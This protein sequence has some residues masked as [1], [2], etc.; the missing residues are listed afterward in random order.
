[1]TEARWTTS[2][3]GSWRSSPSS[4]RHPLYCCCSKRRHRPTIGRTTP[5]ARLIR[6]SPIAT[7]RATRM[8]GPLA[9]KALPATRAPL[10]T[11]PRA[12]NRAARPATGPSKKR[13]LKTTAIARR[14]RIRRNRGRRFGRLRVR[15]WVSSRHLVAVRGV[16]AHTGRTQGTVRT[17]MAPTTRTT[18]PVMD[19]HRRTATVAGWGLRARDVSVMLTTSSRRGKLRTPPI[20]TTAT[21][22]TGTA[23]SAR[24]IRLTP[25]ASRRHHP[26]HVARCHRVVKNHRSHRGPHVRCR[27]TRCF[28]S[29]RSTG[30]RHVS[31]SRSFALVPTPQ[32][33]LEP[34][35]A[36]LALGLWVSV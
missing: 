7:L 28:P 15:R 5:A 8:R 9:K 36:H 32:C 4:S 12:K 21:N 33:C 23:A 17:P 19:R 31:W 26:L 13:R 16:M 11:S 2:K 34:G 6:N 25:D 18:T 29:H 22:A 27:P 35:A 3:L 1:M 24:R 10:A 30:R 20:T 14:D